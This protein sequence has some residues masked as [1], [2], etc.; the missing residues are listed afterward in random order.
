MDVFRVA[1]AKTSFVHLEPKADEKG[2]TFM[3]KVLIGISKVGTGSP[4]LILAISA[5]LIICA[6]LFATQLRFSHF[7]LQWLPEDNF[8]RVAT[9]TVDESLRGSLTLEVI[10][11]TGQTNGLYNP[12]ISRKIEEVSKNI[13]TITTG[14]MFVGKVLSFVDIIKETNRALNENQDEYYTVPNDANLIAQEFLLFES[15]GNNDL[16]SLVDANY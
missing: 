10:V 7:P 9:E 15:S 14:N 1:I 16:E 3:D 11:D 4:K 2:H 12:E 13:N 6:T 8:A 5:M